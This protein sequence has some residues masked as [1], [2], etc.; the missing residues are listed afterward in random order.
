MA[1]KIVQN[2]SWAVGKTPPPI[3]DHSDRK[4]SVIESYLRVY[5]ETVIRDPRI[6]N[7]KITLVDGF[8]GGGVYS[9]GAGTR[10]G[11]PMAILTEVFE[12]SVR[13][14][15]GRQKPVSI[16]AVC[17]FGDEKRDHVEYLRETISQSQFGEAL[18]KTVHLHHRSFV[19]LL[20][21][22]IDD[23]KRR[24]RQGRAIFVL[25]QFGYSAV[26]MSALRTIFD[27]LPKAEVILTFSIDAL[28]NYLQDE[29]S[30]TPLV[31]QFGVTDEFLRSWKTWKGSGNSGRAMAQRALM[32]KMHRFSGAR[33]FTPFMM[34][35]PNDNRHMMVAH[36][37]QS[38]TARDKML[39]VH[40]NL[41][42][43]FK[44]IGKGSLFELGYDARSLS[45]ASLFEFSDM[46]RTIM[47][48]ELEGEL[49][50]QIFDL[51]GGSALPLGELLL[52]MGNKTAATNHD[53]VSTL[54]ILSDAGEIEVLKAEGGQKRPGSRLDMTDLFRVSR[55][56]RLFDRG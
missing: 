31:E 30:P 9:K 21:T 19:D 16:D 10:W 55:Q 44:H 3:E 4:L 18:G 49:P 56:L 5:F 39:G 33:F 45:E 32:N 12:A 1:A 43:T 17:H 52:S 35:S 40:W 15:I 41:K 22:I 6:D 25:D 37:S 53:I 34:F 38:Q 20:P 50:K 51:S 29:S 54:R 7:L 24:Q 36:L 42:N 47:R 48:R 27:E 46:D 28:L 26:P 8:C 13:H 11:S 14:N 2:F 23:I